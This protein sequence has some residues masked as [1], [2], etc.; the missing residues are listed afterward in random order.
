[1]VLDMFANPHVASFEVH[2]A[3]VPPPK[4]RFETTPPARSTLAVVLQ[5]AP[6]SEVGPGLLNRSSRNERVH[7]YLHER[8]GTVYIKVDD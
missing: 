3:Y 4:S 2:I 5:L 7:M 6:R 1:M 8:S